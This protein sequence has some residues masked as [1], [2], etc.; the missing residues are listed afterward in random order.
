MNNVIEVENLTK[1]YP[2]FDKPIERLKEALN[3]FRSNYHKDFYALNN[4]SFSIKKGETVGIIGKNG[5]GKSSLLKIITGVLTPSGGSV[6]TAGRISSLLELGT[7]FNPEYTGIENIYF[8]GTLFGYKKHEIDLKLNSI[9]EFADIG[10]FINQSVKTYSSGMFARLAFATAINIEPDI[11]IVDEALSVGDS[12]FEHKCMAKMRKMI[13]DGVSV[14]FVSHSIDAVRSLCSRAIW[15]ENGAVKM[16]GSAQ[17]ITNIFM[18]DVYLDYNQLSYKN[19][20]INKKNNDELDNSHNH[21]AIDENSYFL[22]DA[23][24]TSS[25]LISHIH[26]SILNEYDEESLHINQNEKFSL[27]VSFVLSQN[28]D[29]LSVGFVIKDKFGIEMTGESI[30]NKYNKSIKGIKG[31]L[32]KIKFS[33]KMILRGGESYSVSLRFNSVSKW[34]RSDNILLYND[35]IAATFDVIYDNKNPMWFKF[36]QDFTIGVEGE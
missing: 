33:S 12:M 26:C 27:L 9:L 35:D 30:F 19:E 3:P 36:R 32:Y 25:E 14:L 31:K 4:V 29:N 13:D 17:E 11:L 21:I 22:N 7:G 5:A 24:F 20:S 6:K 2:L 18:N 28:I 34:D 8:Q 1:I 15:L 10:E 16:D 23:N